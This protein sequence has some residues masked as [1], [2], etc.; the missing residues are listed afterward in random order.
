MTKK[1]KIEEKKSLAKEVARKDWFN[2]IINDIEKTEEIYADPRIKGYIRDHH[3]KVIHTI[4]EEYIPDEDSKNLAQIYFE[5]AKIDG[6]RKRIKN[7]E[8]E[9]KAL[10]KIILKSEIPFAAKKRFI[11]KA[12]EQINS[13]IPLESRTGFYEIIKEY[14]KK[15]KSKND[16]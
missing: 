15:I 5:Q 14:H 10:E 1:D 6:E 16:N 13:Q 8:K 4:I 11:S 12:E 7:V 3:E 2:V 9:L